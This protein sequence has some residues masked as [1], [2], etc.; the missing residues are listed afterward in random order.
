VRTVVEGSNGLPRNVWSCD[1]VSEID[2][3]RIYGCDLHDV[4]GVTRRID[5]F[6]LRVR[7]SCVGI[8]H[9]RGQFVEVVEL[10]FLHRVPA[11]PEQQ[12]VDVLR[13]VNRQVGFNSRNLRFDREVRDGIARWPEAA[14]VAI[15]RSVSP[16]ATSVMVSPGC[17]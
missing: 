11:G 13:R 4:V 6:L 10:H 15:Q 17:S 9:R 1:R 2:L 14:G 5:S 8:I 12:V 7:C 16:S 3:C